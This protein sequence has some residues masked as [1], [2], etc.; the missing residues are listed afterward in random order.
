[1]DGQ[2]HCQ[3]ADGDAVETE[4]VIASVFLMELISFPSSLCLCSSVQPLN[5]RLRAEKFIM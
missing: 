2:R 5:S 3:G 4:R 1:V